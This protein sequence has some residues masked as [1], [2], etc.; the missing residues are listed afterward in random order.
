M[1]VFLTHAFK[2]YKFFSTASK[3]GYILVIYIRLDVA[4]KQNFLIYILCETRHPEL[5]FNVKHLGK[6]NVEVVYM[7]QG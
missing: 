6:I 1:T 2:S 3:Q 5:H 7:G 4:F